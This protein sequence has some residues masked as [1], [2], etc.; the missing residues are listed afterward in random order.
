MTDFNKYRIHLERL[1]NAVSGLDIKGS[2]EAAEL[3]LEAGVPPMIAITEGLAR[4]MRTV[5]EKFSCGEFFVPEV[6]VAARSFYAG[7]KVLKPLVPQ[8]ELP[9]SPRVVIGVVEGDVHDI[10]KNIVRLFM[11][12]AGFSV[13]DL[14]KNIPLRQFILSCREHKP[15]AVAISTLMTTTLKSMD[16]TLQALRREFNEKCP[17]LL[18]GGASVTA[19][20]AA[21]IGADFYGSN[22]NEALRGLKDLLAWQ[23]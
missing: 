18:V 20:F 14:G 2:I 15:A 16:D 7:M 11:E 3:A 10:G 6:L 13:I 19:E 22:G 4:G 9:R 12:S 17:K 21:E 5:G 1:T 23:A 8:S